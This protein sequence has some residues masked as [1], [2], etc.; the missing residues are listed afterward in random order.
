MVWIGVSAGLGTIVLIALAFGFHAHKW[1]IEGVLVMG[2]AVEV[3][4]KCGMRRVWVARKGKPVEVETMTKEEWE[5]GAEVQTKLVRARAALDADRARKQ[6]SQEA[7][8]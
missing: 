7:G 4:H 5:T 1:E 6:S 2:D 8:G 3:C